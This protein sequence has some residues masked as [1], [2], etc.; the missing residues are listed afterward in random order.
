MC[1]YKTYLDEKIQFSDRKIE[2]IAKWRL[3]IVDHGRNE[4]FFFVFLLRL[5]LT[6][7]ALITMLLVFHCGRDLKLVNNN[8]F[9]SSET[10]AT[11][12]S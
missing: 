4:I 11:C 12:I 10:L 6:C 9:T 5:G 2:K 3:D 7:K 8:L 1:K